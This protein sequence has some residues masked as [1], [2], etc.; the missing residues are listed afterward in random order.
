MGYIVNTT[1]LYIRVLTEHF[2]ST[3]TFY[4]IVNHFYFMVDNIF[5]V[6]YTWIRK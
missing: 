5:S 6:R 4:F 2:L 1:F 3:V